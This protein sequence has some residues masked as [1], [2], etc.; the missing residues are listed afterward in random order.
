MLN[1][2][3]IYCLVWLGDMDFSFFSLKNKT[4]KIN[5]QTNKQTKQNKKQNKTKKKKMENIFDSRFEVFSQS[6]FEVIT[7]ATN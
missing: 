4:K 5:K 2:L 1:I 3:I 7:A 6:E